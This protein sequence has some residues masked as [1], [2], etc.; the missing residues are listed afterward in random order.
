MI[1]HR[2]FMSTSTHSILKGNNK[3]L[4][5]IYDWITPLTEIGKILWSTISVRA[6]FASLLLDNNL[7]G[8]VKNASSGLIFVEH[9]HRSATLFPLSVPNIVDAAEQRPLA[10]NLAF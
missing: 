3:S 9:F 8:T 6:S 1:L 7:R 10:L 5:S 2:F 4:S